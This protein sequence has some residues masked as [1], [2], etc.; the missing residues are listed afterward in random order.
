MIEVKIIYS[1]FDQTELDT[2]LADGW[3]IYFQ[4]PRQVWL[5]KNKT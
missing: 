2:L 4:D 3:E 5:R 1:P